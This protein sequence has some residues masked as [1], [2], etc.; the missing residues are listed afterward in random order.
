MR[1]CSLGVSVHCRA[2]SGGQAGGRPRPLGRFLAG[3]GNPEHSGQNQ[4]SLGKNCKP[5]Q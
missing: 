4:S 5:K 2:G 3:A 1:K